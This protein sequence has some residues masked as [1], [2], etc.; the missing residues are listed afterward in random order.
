MKRNDQNP[1]ENAGTEPGL[2]GLLD[3]AL[4]I[5]GRRGETLARLRNA[6]RAGKNLEAL[7]LA[8]ELCGLENEQKVHRTDPRVN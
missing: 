3:A 6:L 4:E 7:T 1:A 8:R 2:S 5:A